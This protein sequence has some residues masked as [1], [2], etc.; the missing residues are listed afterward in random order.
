[1]KIKTRSIIQTAILIVAFAAASLAQETTGGIEGT[2]KDPNGAVVPN[3]TLTITTAQQAA[4]NTTTTGTGAGF[5]RTVQTDEDGFFR[6][7]QIPPGV[8]VITTS[9][10]AGFSEAKYE[11]VSVV[12]GRSTQMTITLNPGTT[13]TTVDVSVS[14]VP[15]VDLDLLAAEQESARADVA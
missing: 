5:R 14:D 15:P 10:V 2:V 11:N 13:T 12:V 4:V 9:P 3:V 7:L 8:Y 6:A 1:M